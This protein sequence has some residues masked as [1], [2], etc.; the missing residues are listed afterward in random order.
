MKT[1]VIIPTYQGAHKIAATLDALERQTR[2]DFE[3][4]LVIDGSSDGTAEVVRRQKLTMAVQIVEQHN[5]GRAGA[6]NAGAKV[7]NGSL[8]VFYDDDMLP[9]P[10][11]FEKH[12]TFHDLHPN[13]I[14]VGNA[15]Q[16]PN[17]YGPDFYR[18]RAHL[19]TEWIRNYPDLP[20]PLRKNNLFMTAANCS[21]EKRDF[22]ELDGFTEKLPDAEDKEFAIRAFKKNIPVF[23][24]KHNQAWHDEAI[25]C[26]S[27][28]RRLR[29]YAEA[30][31]AVQSMHPEFSMADVP[32]TSHTKKW[33]YHWLARSW[34]VDA[35]DHFTILYL[36]PRKIRYRLYGAV[37]FALSEMYPDVT[38]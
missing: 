31:K 25:T 21:M 13:T 4:I 17:D 38:I 19:G 6:R 24:D 37:T 30:N 11:S 20:L 15:P 10:D 5:K 14:L 33:I 23:F 36:I 27:Y 9:A 28:I 1:S 16:R 8:L 26:R 18:Y 34:W 35:I 7:A 22:Q 29:Q 32:G 2:K 3:L 12:V